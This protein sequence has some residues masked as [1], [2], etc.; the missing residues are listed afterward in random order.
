M[1]GNDEKWKQKPQSNSPINGDFYE[2]GK[3]PPKTTSGE[4]SFRVREF[5]GRDISNRK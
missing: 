2:L 5:Y 4:F 1:N 3:K